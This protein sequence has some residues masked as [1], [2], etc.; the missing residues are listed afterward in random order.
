[1]EQKN[2]EYLC[3]SLTKLGFEGVLDKALKAALQLDRKEFDLRVQMTNG[4]RDLNFVFKFE[5]KEEGAFHFLNNVIASCKKENEPVLTH[6][7]FLYRQQ[8]Y[9]M[10]EMVNMLEGRSVQTEFRRDGR[11]VELWRRI[12]FTGKD[13]RG[14]NLLRTTYINNNK[15][16]L[17]L[18][19]NKLPVQGL[20]NEEKQMLLMALKKG[21]A[22]SVVVKQ[23]NNKEK[24]NLAALPHLGIIGVFNAQGERIS[25]Q[26]N[27]LKV[28]GPEETNTLSESTKQM[29]NAVNN[30]K[31]GKEKELDKGAKVKVS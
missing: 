27:M 30:N 26:N 12:D 21:D 28:V 4:E 29:V 7:F 14:N 1:M 9:D 20:N 18:E 5:R 24:V 22:V 17:S 8:G 23:G 3:D 13:E 16:N 19:L 6:D 10:R 15:F 31:L 11:N 2:Y 25:L